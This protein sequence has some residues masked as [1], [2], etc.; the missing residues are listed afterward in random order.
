MKR[1][2]KF[3]HLTMPVL[4]AT[5]A[6]IIERFIDVTFAELRFGTDR[7]S[8]EARWEWWRA[9]VALDE[10]SYNEIGRRT[11]GWDGWN[12][13]EAAVGQRANRAPLLRPHEMPP[14]DVMPT[15][16]ALTFLATR[17]A[18]RDAVVG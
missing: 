5:A 11:G 9:L 15:G 2:Y 18:Q 1:T 8:R 12:V 6:P 7:V 16:P 13:R 14:K 17:L 4:R 3:K 10:Y